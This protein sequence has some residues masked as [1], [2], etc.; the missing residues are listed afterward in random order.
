MPYLDSVTNAILAGD[1]SVIKQKDSGIRLESFYYH[2]LI[3][4]EGH[5]APDL[6]QIGKFD[7]LPADGMIYLYLNRPIQVDFPLVCQWHAF[8]FRYSSLFLFIFLFCSRSLFSLRSRLLI[9]IN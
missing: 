7:R 6:L 5:E 8:S 2:R 4:D 1:E 3:L 9:L